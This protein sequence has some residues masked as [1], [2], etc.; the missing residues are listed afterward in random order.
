MVGITTSMG[1]ARPCCRGQKAS[2]PGGC[3]QAP[4]GEQDRGR[5][6]GK[7]E[8]QEQAASTGVEESQGNA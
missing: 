8:E 2:V 4:W 6:G 1:G 7:A 5:G 3:H